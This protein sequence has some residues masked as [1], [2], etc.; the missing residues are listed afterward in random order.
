[1][2]GRNLKRCHYNQQ[3]IWRGTA[4]PTEEEE[5]EEDDKEEGGGGGGGGGQRTTETME[6]RKAKVEEKEQA[7]QKTNEKY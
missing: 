7:S 5:E 1:M 4:G 6:I 3:Y 2:K